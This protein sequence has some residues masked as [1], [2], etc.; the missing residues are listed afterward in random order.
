MTLPEWFLLH[1][2]PPAASWAVRLLAVTLRLRVVDERH[3]QPFWERR[4][5]VI[6]A[7]WHGRILMIPCLYGRSHT[8]HVMASRS[9]D[10]ELVARFVRRFGFETVRGSTTRG[11]S[12]A[13]RRLARL[14]RRGLE[15]AVIP[16]G[17]LGPGEVVQPG[18]IALARLSGAPIVPVAFSA[19]PAWRLR[20]WDA[21]LIP[22]PFGRGVVCFG[23][24]LTVPP[25][26]D[27][28]RQEA[29]RKELEAALGHL[30]SRADG[31]VQE[32]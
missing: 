12:E 13:L 31:L 28:A 17:P 16:D 22:K 23:P 21:F 19:Y 5:P 20:S 8:I 1:C 7:I 25:D 11:G 3:A 15:V 27:R 30:T 2:A 14:L 6:Y 29:L 26:A 24:P 18:I 4:A 9:R 32:P 10:G